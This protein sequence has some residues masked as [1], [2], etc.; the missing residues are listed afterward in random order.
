MPI[1]FFTRQKRAYGRKGQRREKGVREII[2][3]LR[4]DEIAADLGKV[5]C[6][7]RL[8]KNIGAQTINE[9]NYNGPLRDARR[10][11]KL[12]AIFSHNALAGSTSQHEHKNTQQ[13]NT[14][15]HGEN[16]PSF[17]GKQSPGLK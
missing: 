7:Q 11:V 13:K 12:L 10:A 16:S 1:N 17:I 2:P 4:S 14:E 9:K 3:T 8:L 15:K 6:R 5:P